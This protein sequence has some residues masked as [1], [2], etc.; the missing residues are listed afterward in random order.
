MTNE[1]ANEIDIKESILNS[2]KKQLGILPE[3]KEFDQDIVMNI[4]AAILTL[5]QIGVGPQDYLFTLEDERQTYSD[6]LGEGSVEIPYVKMYLFYKT[7][8]SF[9]PPQ[10]S[11]VLESLKSIASEIEWR[12]NVQV[13]SRSTFEEGGEIS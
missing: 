10:S 8:I 2:V 12:L 13:D 4:N 7:K 1:G 9:D 11:I 3:M 6:F 5:K